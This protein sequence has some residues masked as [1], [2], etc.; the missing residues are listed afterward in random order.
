MRLLVIFGE[1]HFVKFV[2]IIHCN[3]LYD[4]TMLPDKKLKF[5]RGVKWFERVGLF[6]YL[7][8]R[9]RKTR[10]IKFVDEAFALLV[11]DCNQF[12]GSLLNW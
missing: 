4:S 7:K 5:K 8:E 2:V 9:T 11:N 12:N 10:N 1:I 3:I 6:E